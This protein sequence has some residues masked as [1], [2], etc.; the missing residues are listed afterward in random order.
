MKSKDIVKAIGEIDEK[1]LRSAEKSYNAYK[2]REVG[3]KILNGLK[4]VACAFLVIG[5]I[6]ALWLP[7][8]LLPRVPDPAAAPDSS[9]TAPYKDI[10][11]EQTSSDT[12]GT[13]FTDP[14]TETD[15][16]PGIIHF[17]TEGLTWTKDEVDVFYE[18]AATSG[19]LSDENSFYTKEKCYK[20]TPEGFE[21]K[22]GVKID[23]REDIR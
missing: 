18:A 13:G 10:G 4:T 16:Q 17:F 20:V 14:E 8:V 19:L 22:V 2:A 3:G 23:G 15:P 11:T 6:V 12:T 21:E 9:E 1:Y 5:V 7:S